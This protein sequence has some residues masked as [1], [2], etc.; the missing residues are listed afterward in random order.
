MMSGSECDRPEERSGGS[1]PVPFG[2]PIAVVSV[3]I[4][5]SQHLAQLSDLEQACFP[6]SLGDP[7]D[8]SSNG[9]IPTAY[10]SPNLTT[11]SRCQIRKVSLRVEIWSS[12]QLPQ[13]G[14]ATVSMA[15]RLTSHVWELYWA[16]RHTPLSVLIPLWPNCPE[17]PTSFALRN[18]FTYRGDTRDEWGETPWLSQVICL[19]NCRS[20][21]PRVLATYYMSSQQ[22]CN[23]EV[24]I[25]R[26]VLTS[27]WR[28]NQHLW[29]GRESQEGEAG[30]DIIKILVYMASLIQ[31]VK[32]KSCTQLRG[33][34]G[35]YFHVPTLT[36]LKHNE[37]DAGWSLTKCN[38]QH[39]LHSKGRVAS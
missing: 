8:L 13:C 18:L 37:G 11:Q 17:I 14:T 29:Q 27:A 1:Q 16:Q 20:D 3:S 35:C 10:S 2:S 5:N 30:D 22:S 28:P 24:F 34:R 31:L 15:T 6:D 38:R 39:I 19:D 4:G 32:R 23:L 12:P 33:Q 25:Y 9:W 7:V 26:Q 21:N 36:D